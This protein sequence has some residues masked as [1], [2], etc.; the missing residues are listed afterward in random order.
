M[1]SEA[2]SSSTQEVATSISTG[3]RWWCWLVLGSPLSAQFAPEALGTDGLAF[4][5]CSTVNPRGALAPPLNLSGVPTNPLGSSE[6][7]G[8]T[9]G[10][11]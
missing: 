9:S 7:K 2:I 1:S 4:P 3:Q 6:L 8:T 5:G 10:A 11:P